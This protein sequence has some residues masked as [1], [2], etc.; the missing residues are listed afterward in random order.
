MQQDFGRE[1]AAAVAAI[2]EVCSPRAERE[3]VAGMIDGVVVD[4][5]QMLER[6]IATL[7]LR[8]GHCKSDRRYWDTK[9]QMIWPVFEPWKFISNQT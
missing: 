8:L 3:G 6:I 1:S 4:V 5:D 9:S 2:N 7:A